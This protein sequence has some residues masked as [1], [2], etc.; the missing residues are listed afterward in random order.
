MDS[1]VKKGYKKWLHSGEDDKSLQQLWDITGS[2]NSNFE[3]DLEK[4]L[5]S[6]RNRL[7]TDQTKHVI[8][9]LP[10]AKV[11]KVAA[12][13]LFVVGAAYLYKNQISGNEHLETI[14][15]EAG[16]HKTFSLNDG[17]LITLNRSSQLTFPENFDK[18]IRKASLEGEAFFEIARDESRPF[19]V[20]TSLATVEVLG[21]SFNIRSQTS[22]N[23]FEVYVKT[24]KV[25]VRIN[26]TGEALVLLPGEQVVYQK[27]TEKIVHSQNVASAA[28][29]WKEGVAL[30]KEKTFSEIFSGME[31]MYDVEIDIKNSRLLSCKFTLTAERG[32][33]NEAF[34]AIK[35][36]CPVNISK[37][38]PLQYEVTGRC[39]Q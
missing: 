8:R 28:L 14:A 2:Y 37:V 32:K 30:F 9:L 23:V 16:I 21:T 15:S 13:V 1:K 6:F 20:N 36:A 10:F 33:L 25:R 35:V 34:S 4:G 39:C 19:L 12:A 24:G 5:S 11:W 31:R 18:N 38:A 27:D 17:S 29:A 7:T 22:E 26:S 3:P